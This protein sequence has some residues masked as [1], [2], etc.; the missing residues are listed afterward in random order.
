M[1]E[2]LPEREEQIYL[3]KLAEQAERYDEMAEHMRAACMFGQELN[4]V[5]RN[6][7]AV[8]FKQAVGQRRSAWRTVSNL[9]QGEIS[10]G[11]HMTTASAVGYRKE[12]EKEL[13]TLCQVILSLLKDILI[14]GATSAEAKV[15]FYKSL[16]DYHRYIAEISDGKDKTDETWLAKKAY[17]D[18]TRIAED[19]LS[20]THVA[21]LGL[22]LNHAVFQ[23]ECMQA[24]VEAVRIGRK[25]F[26]DAVREIDNLGEESVKDS[27]LVMQLLRDN[28]T[29]WTADPND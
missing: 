14:P 6:H 19:A 15:A 21:R 18:G 7:L 17:E 22:A 5:E 26:E 12:I 3:A 10:K 24:P 4:G 11:N 27:S 20:V 28:L 23:Y 1:G 2:A 9:E 8:A 16:G 29:L 25:A 13:K